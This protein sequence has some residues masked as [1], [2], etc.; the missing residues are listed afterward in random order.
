MCISV[1]KLGKNLAKM[2]NIADKINWQPYAI[3]TH[4]WLTTVDFLPPCDLF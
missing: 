1:I 3:S 4:S 2:S